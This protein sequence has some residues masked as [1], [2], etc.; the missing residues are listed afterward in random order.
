MAHI[1]SRNLLRRWNI[2]PAV[3][4]TA[5]LS[6]PIV[7]TPHAHTANIH[8]W[9]GARSYRGLHTSRTC[10][11]FDSH[12]VSRFNEDVYIALAEEAAA[13]ER[14][15]RELIAHPHVDET[16]SASQLPAQSLTTAQHKH[17]RDQHIR[18]SRDTECPVSRCIVENAEF[19]DNIEVERWGNTVTK[20]VNAILDTGIDGTVGFINCDELLDQYPLADFDSTE[21]RLDA[22]LAREQTGTGARAVLSTVATL[23]SPI[24]TLPAAT[25]AS[26]VVQARLVGTVAKAYGYN[27]DSA[28][29]RSMV[30]CALLGD[31]ELVRD[32]IVGQDTA[33]PSPSTS[34]EMRLVLQTALSTTT[35]NTALKIA[36]RLV[37]ERLMLMAG[38]NLSARAASKMALGGVAVVVLDTQALKSTYECANRIFARPQLPVP[39]HF[40]N[41]VHPPTSTTLQVVTQDRAYA[42]CRSDIDVSTVPLSEPSFYIPRVFS[43]IG[44]HRV[45]TFFEQGLKWGKIDNVE[46]LSLKDGPIND[47]ERAMIHFVEWNKDNTQAMETRKKL[48]LGHEVTVCYDDP[49]FWTIRLGRCSL[50]AA[51]WTTLDARNS[52][53]VRIKAKQLEERRIETSIRLEKSMANRIFSQSRLRAY[54]KLKG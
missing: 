20:C 33:T 23:F 4:R 9:D 8:I 28:K 13:R 1:A 3:V 10:P 34:G 48:L 47:F 2:I 51:N 22:I 42:T 7:R 39:P 17:E 45:Q 31:A 5:C 25:C 30:M 11:A 46:M 41:F 36:E 14:K 12:K 18:L 37:V 24:L 50:E 19:V 38:V 27:L 43:N 40:E 52:E 54:T 15:M 16:G 6:S 29:V 53:I 26:W 21:Q 35:S 32:L 49:W 44:K